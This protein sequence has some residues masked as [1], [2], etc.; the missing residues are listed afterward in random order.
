MENLSPSNDTLANGDDAHK[1]VMCGRSTFFKKEL[2]YFNSCHASS[3]KKCDIE[4]KTESKM[5]DHVVTHRIQESPDDNGTSANITSY[6]REAIIKK[7]YKISELFDF[8]DFSFCFKV[9]CM[10]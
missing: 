4:T 2:V 10:A 3:C 8:G 9:T 1:G 6:L 5:T 7:I